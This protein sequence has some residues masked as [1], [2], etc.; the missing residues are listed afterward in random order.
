[1]NPLSYIVRQGA[2][3]LAELSQLK[4]EFPKDMETLKAWAVE[5]MNE[6]GISVSSNVIS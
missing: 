2:A 1:M 3:T 6:L 5:E 4:R